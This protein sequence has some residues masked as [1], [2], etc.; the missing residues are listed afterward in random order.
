TQVDGPLDNATA[1]DVTDLVYYASG[2]GDNSYRLNT[3]TVH[4]G[5]TASHTDLTTTYSVYDKWGNAK[6]VQTPDTVV[7]TY[8]TSAIGQITEQRTTAAA[9]DEWVD[10]FYNP[11]GS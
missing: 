11:D 9:G 3:S 2:L 6:N 8:T 10:Y 5:T 4:V 1:Y 7:K